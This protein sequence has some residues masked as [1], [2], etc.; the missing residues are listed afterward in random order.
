[1]LDFNGNLY[2]SIN[3]SIVKIDE[4]ELNSYCTFHSEYAEAETAHSGEIIEILHHI[5]S[6]TP[7]VANRK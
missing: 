5:K 4:R 7:A 3:K 2:V 6:D 1:M